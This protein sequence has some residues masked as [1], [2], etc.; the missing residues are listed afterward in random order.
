MTMVLREGCSVW[1]DQGREGVI[2]FTSDL[3]TLVE[4]A[5]GYVECVPAARRHDVLSSVRL[6]ISSQV[7]GVLTEMSNLMEEDPRNPFR[8]KSRLGPGPEGEFHTEKN[9]WSCSGAN[10]SYQCVGIA[11]ENKGNVLN[12]KVDPEKKA[13]YNRKYKRFR[14]R[15]RERYL[16]GR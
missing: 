9:K 16:G 5:S 4:W 3:L 2:V 12:L 6:G 11:T 15:M 1:D 14:K 8:H 13:A 7:R 10:Y